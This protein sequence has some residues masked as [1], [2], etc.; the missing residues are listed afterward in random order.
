M[1]SYKEIVISNI[2]GLNPTGTLDFN[3][4]F[5][6]NGNNNI[7]VNANE[8]SKTNLEKTN[9]NIVNC[10]N[11]EKFENYKDNLKINYFNLNYIQILLSLIIILITIYFLMKFIKIKC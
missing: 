8:A 3:G 1:A 9:S 6:M 7:V 11:I 10:G 2:A 5:S 4:T